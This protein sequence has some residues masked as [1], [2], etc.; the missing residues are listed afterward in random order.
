MIGEVQSENLNPQLLTRVE[1]SFR[2][3]SFRG[4]CFE[5]HGRLSFRMLLEEGAIFKLRKL[6]PNEFYDVRA[7]IKF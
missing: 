1:Y 5:R 4:V 3:P 6:F 2:G 7:I